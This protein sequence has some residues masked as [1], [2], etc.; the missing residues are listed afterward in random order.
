MD[1]LYTLK[2]D[3]SWRPIEVIDAFKGASMVFG[4]RAR[5]LES[6]DTGPHPRLLFPSVI[7]LKTYIHKR[8]FTMT[9]NRKNVVWRDKNTCQYCGGFFSLKDLTMDHVVPQ[10]YG[11]K[12]TWNNIVAACKRCNGKKGHK[13]LEEISMNLLTKPKK[14]AITIRD[15]YRQIRFPKCWDKYI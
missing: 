12:K 4:G 8:K 7:V 2:L 3:A 6:Y 5:V 14:P 11:G 10:Y 9:C 13:K 15:Y 1:K